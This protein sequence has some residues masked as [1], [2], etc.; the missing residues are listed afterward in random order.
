MTRRGFFL[1][2]AGAANQLGFVLLLAAALFASAPF[3]ARL[4]ARA[5][6]GDERPLATIFTCF[7]SGVPLPDAQ[8]GRPGSASDRSGECVLCQTL[9]CGDAPLAARPGLVGVAPIQSETLSWMVADRAAPTPRPRL[10]N[11]ARAP[12]LAAA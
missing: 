3:A 11:R 7:A 6:A 10:S 4:A 9:C 5:L 12:P 2:R 1:L 8:P